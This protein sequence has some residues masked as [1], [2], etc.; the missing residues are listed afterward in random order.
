MRKLLFILSCLLVVHQLPAQLPTLLK[1]INAGPGSS[2]IELNEAYGF[3]FVDNNTLYFINETDTCVWKTDGTN[4]GTAKVFSYAFIYPYKPYGFAIVGSKLFFAHYINNDTTKLWYA[5]ISNNYSLSMV[6]SFKSIGN[7][8]PTAAYIKC[9]IEYNGKLLFNAEPHAP[10]FITQ[11]GK[12][13][14]VSDGTSAGTQMLADIATHPTYGS[15]QSGN[16]L[17][18][19]KAY[20]KVYFTAAQ[21]PTTSAAVY[22]LWETDGTTPGTVQHTGGIISF[23]SNFPI[24]SPKWYDGFVYF[25]Y[26]DNSSSFPFL[27]KI[28][29]LRPSAI[30]RSTAFYRLAD[31]TFLNGNIYAS[32]INYANG[33]AD[34]TGVELYKTDTV[35]SSIPTATLVKNINTSGFSASGPGNL[36]VLNNRVYFSCYNSS[37]SSMPSL[38]YSDGTTAGTQRITD[39]NVQEMNICDSTLYIVANDSVQGMELRALNPVN[40]TIT[41]Y[42]QTPGIGNFLSSPHAMY[43]KPLNGTL[44]FMADDGNLGT[45]LWRTCNPDFFSGIRSLEKEENVILFPNPF[46]SSTTLRIRQ[47]PLPEKLELKLYDA[48]G[49]MVRSVRVNGSEISINRDELTDGIYFYSLEGAKNFRKTG[50]LIIN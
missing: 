23:G 20:G 47:T 13:L 11:K 33:P 42:D 46:T 6:A 16:P 14:W 34:T 50:K 27:Y 37:S 28:I 25:S 24:I 36:T 45:E 9:S 38:Y 21:Y 49:K 22:S 15:Y 48:L 30:F 10:T 3:S 26:E 5:D 19:F 43:F 44:L 41:Y 35:L 39:M 2:N 8:A 1:D 32:G 29:K 40:N 17:N 12:E 7:G 18:F 31:Y 4:A